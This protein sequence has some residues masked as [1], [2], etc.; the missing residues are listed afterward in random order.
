MVYILTENF[1][2][3]KIVGL[4]SSDC[5]RLDEDISTDNC[6]HWQSFSLSIDQMR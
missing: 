6:L 3:A 5:A 4:R 1:I 2:S